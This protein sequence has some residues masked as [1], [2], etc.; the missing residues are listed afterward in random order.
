[1]CR[2]LIIGC[3]TVH[4][5]LSETPPNLPEPPHHVTCIKCGA[6]TDAVYRRNDNYCSLFFI[7]ICRVGKGR[8]FLACKS[9]GYRFGDFGTTICQSCRTASPS[10]FNYCPRC[11]V[12]ESNKPYI[13][14]G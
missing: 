7:P 11:G 14:G 3:T 4:R 9:C 10:H 13:S 5:V 12:P 6:E 2:C 1:M 8:P